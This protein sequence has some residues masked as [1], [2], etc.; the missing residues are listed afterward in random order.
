MYNNNDGVCAFF[1]RPVFC[2]PTIPPSRCQNTRHFFV[3]NTS[4]FIAHSYAVGAAGA[5]KGQTFY[6]LFFCTAD[7]YRTQTVTARH[8]AGCMCDAVYIKYRGIKTVLLPD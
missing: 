4:S 7:S 8:K 6:V 5:L 3:D 2:L 1:L